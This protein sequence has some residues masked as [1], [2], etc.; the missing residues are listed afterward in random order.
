MQTFA[1]LAIGAALLSASMVATPSA[2][3]GAEYCHR[4]TDGDYVCIHAVYGKRS[5]RGITASIN[6]RINN[7]RVNCYNRRYGSTSLIAY[8]CW[9]Y[10]A[11]ATEPK[12]F[13]PD[14]TK[15]S[16]AIFEGSNF[17]SEDQ[18]IDLEKVKNAMPDEMR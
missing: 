11:I 18:A 13:D 10:N 7:F 2:I 12:D 17:L 6:G 1:H 16:L 14:S 5:N 3:A 8:A 4:D 15:K 9:S